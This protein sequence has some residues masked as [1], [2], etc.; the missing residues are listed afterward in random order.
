MKVCVFGTGAVGG[1]IATRLLAA[2]ADEISLVARGRQLDALRS[3]GLVLRSGGTEVKASVPV[4]TDDPAT[5][6]PRT[7]CWSR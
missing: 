5:S 7:S 6:L 3:R 4:A 1:S 2:G